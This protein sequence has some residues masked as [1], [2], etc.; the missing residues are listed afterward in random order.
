MAVGGVWHKK[1]GGGLRYSC[2]MSECNYWMYF[3]WVCPG[4][5]FREGG[6][7]QGLVFFRSRDWRFPVADGCAGLQLFTFLCLSLLASS[8][9]AAWS[10]H[11]IFVNPRCV[12]ASGVKQLVQIPGMKYSYFTWGT[13]SQ[14]LRMWHPENKGKKYMYTKLTQKQTHKNGDVR[15]IQSN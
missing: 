11:V 12:G 3:L 13:I 1:G 9:C 7:I 10:M 5:E 2:M 8:P 6:V 4:V 15:I 14:R